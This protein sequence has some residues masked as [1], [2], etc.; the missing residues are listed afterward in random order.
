MYSFFQENIN[1][2]LTFAVNAIPFLFI[3]NCNFTAQR[4]LGSCPG[5]LKNLVPR[6]SCKSVVE[7]SPELVIERS[8]IRLLLGD[9]GFSFS[10][11]AF[12][13]KLQAGHC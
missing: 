6:V 3:V 5:H 7:H 4:G 13:K 12:H 10:E 2:N 11:Y 9:F 8:K 1:A